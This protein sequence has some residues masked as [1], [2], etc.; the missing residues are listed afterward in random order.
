MIFHDI[1]LILYIY[2]LFSSSQTVKIVIAKITNNNILN[3]VIIISL[4]YMFSCQYTFA[5]SLIFGLTQPMWTRL[6]FGTSASAGVKTYQYIHTFIYINMDRQ[7]CIFQR[8]LFNGF[9][10]WAKT[11]DLWILRK[12]NQLQTT[13][14]DRKK[15]TFSLKINNFLL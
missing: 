11:F 1:F 10:S 4:C 13:S 3:I 12:Y 14:Y 5:T 7:I 6:S 2:C 9:L 8:F 15:Y